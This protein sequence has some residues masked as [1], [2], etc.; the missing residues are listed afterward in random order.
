MKF[1]TVDEAIRRANNSSTGLGA[2]VWSKDQARAEEIA[3]RLEVGSVWINTIAIPAANAYLSGHKESGLGGEW[4]FDG[5][6]AYCNAQVI[7]APTA[8]I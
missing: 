7:H 2:V 6:K 8:K 1:S 4:G 5:W 3:R